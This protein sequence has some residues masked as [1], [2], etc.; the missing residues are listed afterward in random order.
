M[1][2]LKADMAM[3][4]AKDRVGDMEAT[5]AILFDLYDD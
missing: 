2:L 1:H 3:R 5:S 4:M